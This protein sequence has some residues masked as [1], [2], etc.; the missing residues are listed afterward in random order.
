MSWSAGKRRTFRLARVGAVAAACVVAGCG[1]DDENEPPTP[2]QARIV[3]LSRAGSLVCG[4]SDTF[5]FADGGPYAGLR[6][7]LLDARNFG[8]GGVVPVAFVFRPAIDHIR[9]RALGRADVLV[10]NNPGAAIDAIAQQTMETFVDGGGRVL[11]LGDEVPTFLAAKGECVADP[12]A[13]VNKDAPAVVAGPFGALGGSF[14]T[15]YN[16]AFASPV[17]EAIVLARNEK[18]PNALLLDRVASRAGA[19]RVIAF[20][21]DEVFSSL[22]AGGCGAGKFLPGSSNEI[23]ALNTFAFLAAPPGSP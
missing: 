1:A 23:L 11:F 3:A 8:P 5:S 6:S 4:G 15:G 9:P 22:T 13:D 19:G 7:A 14:A 20:G 17:A 21:D 2:G 16:C 10:V 12:D 18:G